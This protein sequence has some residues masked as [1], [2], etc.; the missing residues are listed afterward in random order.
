[1][2]SRSWE[3]VGTSGNG[4]CMIGSQAGLVPNQAGNV[5]FLGEALP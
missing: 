4:H 1:M 5:P 2:V 3:P